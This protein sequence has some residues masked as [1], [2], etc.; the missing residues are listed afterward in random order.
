M[1]G[2]PTSGFGVLLRNV[3]ARLEPSIDFTDSQWMQKLY[4][5]LKED[6]ELKDHSDFE[7]QVE[8]PKFAKQG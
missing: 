5:E 2:R 7:D 3:V 1:S 6:E 8:D 4:D